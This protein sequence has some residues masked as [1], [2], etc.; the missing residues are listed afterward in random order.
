MKITR[1]I[2]ASALF[3]IALVSAV[4]PQT[5]E[6]PNTSQWFAAKRHVLTHPKEEEPCDKNQLSL[7]L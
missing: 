1:F 4:P 6:V 7:L 2:T 3:L 5:V